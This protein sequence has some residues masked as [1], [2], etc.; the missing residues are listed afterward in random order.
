[1]ICS[2][3]RSTLPV[4]LMAP[5]T[6]PSASPILSIMVPKYSVFSVTSL[7][8]SSGVMPLALRSSYSARAYPSV[9]GSVAG[10]TMATPSRLTPNCA[11]FALTSSAGPTS[12]TRAMPRSTMRAAA[13]TVRSSVPSASTMCRLAAFALARICSMADIHKTS[14]MWY[15]N[16]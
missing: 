6:M 8:A 12:V 4:E 13:C 2:A 7:R 3:G 16:Y 14:L 1:M 11:A 10:S 15:D 9:R 5:A